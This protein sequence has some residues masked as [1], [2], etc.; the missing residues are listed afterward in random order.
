MT[1]TLLDTTRYIETPEG[2]EVSIRAAG[3]VQRLWAFLI[4]LVVRVVL[5][6]GIMVVLSLFGLFALAGGADSDALDFVIT[7]MLLLVLFVVE[8]FYPVVLEVLWGGKTVGKATMGLRVAMDDGTPITWSASLLRNLLR[9]ADFL[10]GFYLTGLVFSLFHPDSKRLGDVAAGTVVIY[11]DQKD[12]KPRLPPGP[13]RGPR[14]NLSIGERRTIVDFAERGALFSPAR[15]AEL[16]NIVEPLT[17]TKDVA[18]VAR[19]VEM[20]RWFSGQESNTYSAAPPPLT[21]TQPP[22]PMTAAAPV[23]TPTVQP[24]EVQPTAAA[25][26]EPELAPS[27][28][29]PPPPLNV[30]PAV[31]PAA[32]DNPYL[33]PGERAVE[34]PAPESAET[35]VDPHADYKP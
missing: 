2:I 1:D 29:T 3:P 23:V 16:A 12:A 34:E 14:A 35:P 11:R 33:N 17:D 15:R 27:V 4:D 8:W 28:V 10:P 9:V 20:A 26:S 18:G 7:G 22:L 24:T 32:P 19:L 5:V 25:A 6:V 30:T 21:P 31:R 13:A